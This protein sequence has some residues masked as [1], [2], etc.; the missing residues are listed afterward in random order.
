MI[1]QPHNAHVVKYYIEMSKK[2]TPWRSLL[3]TWFM[4]CIFAFLTGNILGNI[5]AFNDFIELVE[6]AECPRTDAS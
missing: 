2:F 4:T 6:R 1:S 3:F 5:E